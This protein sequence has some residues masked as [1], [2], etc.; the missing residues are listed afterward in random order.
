ML[1]AF[2]GAFAIRCRAGEG[3]FHVAEQLRFHQAFGEGRA[4]HGHQGTGPA[5]PS[6]QLSRGEFFPG[7]GGTENEHRK[8]RSRHP[9]QFVKQRGHGFAAI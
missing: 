8:L 2:D 6:M 3:A 9:R 1:G 7:S 4:I 5:R